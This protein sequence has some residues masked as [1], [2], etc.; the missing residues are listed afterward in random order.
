ME[1]FAVLLVGM[2]ILSTFA[3]VVLVALW[4]QDRKYREDHALGTG[5]LARTMATGAVMT[6]IPCWYFAGTLIWRIVNGGIP[7]PSVL[8]PVSSLM[9]VLALGSPVY[10]ALKVLAVQKKTGEPPPWTNA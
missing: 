10:L 1:I 9:I 5:W 2:G 3:T 7:V 8:T 6:L 4:R